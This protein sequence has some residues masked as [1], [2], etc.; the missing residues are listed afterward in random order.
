MYA[1]L[2]IGNKMS[3]RCVMTLRRSIIVTIC[4][5]MLLVGGAVALAVTGGES[6]SGVRLSEVAIHEEI[7]LLPSDNAGVGGWCLATLGGNEAGKSYCTTG[8][9]RAFGGPIVAE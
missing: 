7:V 3:V 9:P 6:D 2:G 4:V 1:A 5:G 8:G